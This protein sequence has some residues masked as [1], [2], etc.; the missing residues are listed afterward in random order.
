MKGLCFFGIIIF[1]VGIAMIPT[2]VFDMRLTHSRQTR[3]RVAIAG[4]GIALSG[5]LVTLLS[6]F[7]KSTDIVLVAFWGEMMVLSGATVPFLASLFSGKVK[8]FT[9]FFISGPLM[10]SGIITEF[11][12]IGRHNGWW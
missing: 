11:F 10:I 6:L 8:F 2:A 1:V 3:G 9:F 5:A 12:A 4:V 7:F